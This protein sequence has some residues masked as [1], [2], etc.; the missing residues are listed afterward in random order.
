MRK[1]VKSCW[2]YSIYLFANQT[3]PFIIMM[4]DDLGLYFYHPCV[5][6][7][8]QRKYWPDNDQ[9]MK[10]QIIF[11]I[12]KF[13]GFWERGRNVRISYW[14]EKFIQ[15][16]DWLP[17]TLERSKRRIIGKRGEHLHSFISSDIYSKYISIEA[18]YHYHY[19]LLNCLFCRSLP[20]LAPPWPR[21]MRLCW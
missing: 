6:R 20:R 11:T 16:S 8:G 21:R 3:L 13:G 2:L 14:S 15:S 1:R 5:R 10:I 9:L 7:R 18:F 12:T 19:N 17:V 4:S